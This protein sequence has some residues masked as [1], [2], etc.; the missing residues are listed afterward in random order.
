MKTIAFLCI[1]LASCT[2]EFSVQEDTEVGEDVSG[3]DG[4]DADQDVGGGERD[5]VQE[6]SDGLQEPDEDKEAVDMVEEENGE[7]EAKEDAEE[8]VEEDVL[9]ED[10]LEEAM[11]GVEE[12]PAPDVL[13]D[14]EPEPCG[15]CEEGYRCY[16]GVCAKECET[17]IDCENACMDGEYCHSLGICISG[18]PIACDDEDTDTIDGCRDWEYRPEGESPCCGI[19]DT[20]HHLCRFE[21]VVADGGYIVHAN[22]VDGTFKLRE[23]QSI[24][25]GP[26]VLTHIKF[27]TNYDHFD[28]YL[29]DEA[30]GI[31]AV[32]PVEYPW[33]RITHA[34]EPSFYIRLDWVYDNAN[35]WGSTWYQSPRLL[36]TDDPECL[37]V[38][39]IVNFG[40]AESACKVCNP[41]AEVPDYSGCPW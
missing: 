11:D 8:V 27:V 1:L 16:G 21:A 37:F 6:A 23:P 28:A 24:F 36:P 26:C 14:T 10:A 22:S 25:T 9:E 29:V 20:E 17:T 31:I 4:I 34:E 15:G 13:E 41:G 40:E 30:R 33:N 39:D 5:V 35:V 2:S 12:V 19:C 32:L 3:E 38:A 18:S 7:E